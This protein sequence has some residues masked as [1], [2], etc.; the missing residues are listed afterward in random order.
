MKKNKCKRC[1]LP[2]HTLPFSLSL[3]V[4]VLKM[5]YTSLIYF[6]VK[7]STLSDIKQQPLIIAHES[8]GHLDGSTDMR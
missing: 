2:L 8:M 6:C 4:I 1:L 7:A 5:A 3:E